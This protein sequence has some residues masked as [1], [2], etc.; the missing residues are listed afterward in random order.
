MQLKHGLYKLKKAL[1]FLN[2]S[3]RHFTPFA[4]HT[5]TPSD[6]A[7][8]LLRLPHSQAALRSEQP[9]LH[10]LAPAWEAWLTEEA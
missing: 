3:H 1:P 8:C 6:P 10:T 7:C 4:L 9:P 5:S 2:Y